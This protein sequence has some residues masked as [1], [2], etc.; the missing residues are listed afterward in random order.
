MKTEAKTPAEI[1]LSLNVISGPRG[2]VSP[3]HDTET[4]KPLPGWPCI[5]YTVELLDSRR[6]VVWTGDFRLGVGH[7]KPSLYRE[8][9]IGARASANEESLI[10]TWAEKPYAEF[11]DKQLWADAAAC[12]ARMQKVKPS[13]NDVCCSLLMDGSAFF[14]GERF[15]EWAANYGY[16]SDGIRAK[17]TFE[18]CDRIGRDLLRAL[19]RDELA[20][21]REWASNH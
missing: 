18:T 14:D 1:G 3:Q 15:E 12:L 5:A 7:V 19:S 6:R 11:T 4:G 20:G 16:S 9:P 10:R 8:R 21:L 13:L 17:E 2:E